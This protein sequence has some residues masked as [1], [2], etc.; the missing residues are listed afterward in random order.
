MNFHSFY[1]SSCKRN[2]CPI[3]RTIVLMGPLPF[4]GNKGQLYWTLENL[5]PNEKKRWPGTMPAA[6]CPPIWLAGVQPLDAS[7][8]EATERSFVIGLYYDRLGKIDEGWLNRWSFES[9]FL[10][11]FDWKFQYVALQRKVSGLFYRKVW[12]G[13]TWRMNLEL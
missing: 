3:N 8:F 1:C 9:I 6:D 2:N 4:F 5:E 11:Q 7:W 12:A 10:A 13:S